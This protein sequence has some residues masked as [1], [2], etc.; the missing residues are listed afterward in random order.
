MDCSPVQYVQIRA[1][2]TACTRFSEIGMPI[3][4]ER[5]ERG[6]KVSLYHHDGGPLYSTTCQVVMRASERSQRR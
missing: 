1:S 5:R 2:D 6:R 4:A 3:F